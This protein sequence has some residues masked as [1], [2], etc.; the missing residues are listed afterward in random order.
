VKTTIDIPDDLF[1]KTQAMAS[2]RGK[3]LKDLMTEA[4]RSYMKL[5][6]EASTGWRRVFGKADRRQV[7]EVDEMV[8][9]EFGRVDPEAWQ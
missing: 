9:E 8:V 4:L 2:L 1:R 7:E 6:A 3:T 5:P